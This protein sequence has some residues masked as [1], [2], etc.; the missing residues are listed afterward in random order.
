MKIDIHEKSQK[1]KSIFKRLHQVHKALTHILIFFFY[2]Y[3]QHTFV[4]ERWILKCQHA[5]FL[6]DRPIMG[7]QN[8]Q[9]RFC[10]VSPHP[11]CDRLKLNWQLPQT[12][13]RNENQIQTSVDSV[14]LM[15]SH[16]MLMWIETSNAREDKKK[17]ILTCLIR[18]LNERST[19]HEKTELSRELH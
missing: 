17:W 15:L 4:I 11:P 9:K 12:N 1:V 18:S 10:T 8:T 16:V 6:L 19:A 14:K 3:V 5:T 13:T 7:Q 2:A